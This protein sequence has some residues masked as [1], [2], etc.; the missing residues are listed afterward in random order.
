MVK[1]STTPRVAVLATVWFEGCHTDVIVPKIVEGWTIDGVDYTADI[2]IASI[3]LEQIGCEQGEDIGLPF[4]EKHGILRAGSIGEALAAGGS[5]VAVDGV[6]IIGEHGDFELNEVGQ[7]LYPRRRFFDAAVAAMVASGTT[8][9]IFNDKGIGYSARDANAMVADAR[10]LGIGFGAGSTIPLAWRVPVGAEW[11]LHAPMT[12]ALLIGWGPLERYGFHALEGLQAHVE[13]RTGGEVG[14]TAVRALDASHARE[15]LENGHIDPHLLD[16][17]FSRLELKAQERAE[18]LQS[19]NGVIEI[20][21]ADGLRG[22]VVMCEEVTRQFAVACRGDSDE[23]SC[24]MWLQFA[25]H[26][27]FSFLVRQIEHLMHAGAPQIPIERTQLTTGVLD[28]AMR[29][30]SSG[31]PIDTPELAISYLAAGEISGTG[32][33]LE[34]P[35]GWT[36]HG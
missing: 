4:I 28:A 8:V 1:Q 29:S 20:T 16:H 21:Y 23:F 10:R 31:E 26:D 13:R 36:A 25:P 35:I 18:A 6:I 9:P 12:D 2:E 7:Q 5:G 11:P 30:W 17:A 15:A 33:S 14:V 24:Q 32:I 19:V 3:Y 34:R 27:H 22:T